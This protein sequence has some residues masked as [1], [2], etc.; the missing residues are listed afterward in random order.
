MARMVRAALPIGIILA[1]AVP[2]STA[3]ARRYGGNPAA[4]VTAETENQLIA[5]SL[6]DGKVLRRVA[7]PEDPQNVVAN[8]KVV[9]VISPRAGAVTLLG[10][11]SLRVT[12][13][14]RGF[15]S[16]HLAVLAPTVCRRQRPPCRSRWAY[17][18]DDPRGQLDVISLQQKR[19][20]ARLAVGFGAHHLTVSPDGRRLWIALGEHARELVIVDVS[21]PEHPRVVSRFEPGFVAHD[22]AF[23]PNGKR[24]WVTSSEISSVTV[25]DSRSRRRLFS[26]AAGPA[27]QH[28][29]FGDGPRNAYVTSGYGRRIESVDP[30]SGRIL[31]VRRIPYGSFN[32]APMG[33]F[34]VTPSLIRGTVTQ[35]DPK[36]RIRQTV[37][38]A[39]ATRGVATVVW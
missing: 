4:V 14:L 21:R 34:V 18:T 13:V 25:F 33:S 15:A 37:K 10:A 35:L 19:V 39:P 2:A 7:V 20:V 38:V 23:S 1:L 22:V 31:R 8:Q 29:A 24:V 3:V 9:V 27:P 6:P 11:R 12:K 30:G 28:V 36:L 17:V 5:V 26:V 32:L 16:P